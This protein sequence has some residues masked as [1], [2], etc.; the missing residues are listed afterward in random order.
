MIKRD[1]LEREDS[2]LNRAADDEPLFVLRA[3][4]LLAVDLVR[5]WVLRAHEKGV[6]PEKI[7]EAR[8]I[9]EQFAA[10]PD[11]RLPD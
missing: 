1:E 6:N 8:E 2:C 10:W 5:V 7:R 3:R 9:A 4:D 11:K